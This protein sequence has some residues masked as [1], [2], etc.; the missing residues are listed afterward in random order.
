MNIN[1][2]PA[3][4][5]YP[6]ILAR[7]E[8]NFSKRNRRGCWEWRGRVYRRY[9]TFSC[10]DGDVR[11]H[12]LSYRIYRG[13][14]PEGLFVCHRCDN[15]I[16]VNPDHLF[17]GTPADNCRDMI[18]KGRAKFYFG[19]SSTM[20]VLTAEQVMIIRASNE[21]RSVFAERYGVGCSTI[22]SAATGV[23]WKHLPNAQPPRKKGV[24][25]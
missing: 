25:Y 6:V 15:P 13:P 3:L 21:P 16:C 7:F 14:I 11:A 19:I 2:I 9:G 23:S 10:K 20:Q 5:D 12:R 24:D 1:D 4:R 22:T 18:S 8:M 17:L